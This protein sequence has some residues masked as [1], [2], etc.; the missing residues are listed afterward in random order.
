MVDTL[1]NPKKDVE[2]AEPADSEDKHVKSPSE[3]KE[4]TVDSYN[5]ELSGISLPINIVDCGDYVFHYNIL[6]PEIDF[7][8]E[9]LLDETKRSLVSEVQIETRSAMDPGRYADLKDKFLERSKE[10]LKNVLKKSSDEDVAVL[11]RIVVNDMIGLGE[12]EYLLADPRIEEIVINSSRDVVWT[13]HKLHGWLK[14]NI[15]IK[16]EEMIMNYASRIA[17]E[18]GREI[19]HLEPLLDAHQIGRAHV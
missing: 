13:Y 8:T 18:V 17:R 19:T 14:T 11:S 9:A 6:L 16:S 4:I 2:A 7:V 15:R 1:S 10:K 5:I 3:A 12:I